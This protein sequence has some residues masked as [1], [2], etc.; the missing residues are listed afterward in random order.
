MLFPVIS[1]LSYIVCC[2]YSNYYGLISGGEDHSHIYYMYNSFPAGLIFIWLGKWI[3]HNKSSLSAIGRFGWV[4][5][6]LLLLFVEN[7]VITSL[8]CRDGNNNDCYLSLVGLAPAI[9]LW[10]E[11]LPKV[12]VAHINPVTL[13]RMSTIYYCTH[14]TIIRIIMYPCKNMSHIECLVLTLCICTII[15]L[16]MLRLSKT[17]L[18][19]VFKYSY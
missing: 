12:E 3:S 9:V 15:S 4:L 17:K 19:G 11:A 2:L 5:F 16:I 10:I 7:H 1:I 6:F 14:V 18:F 8:G 13:R